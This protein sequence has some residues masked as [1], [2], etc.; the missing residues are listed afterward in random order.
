MCNLD[1]VYYGIVTQSTTMRLLIN[2]TPFHPAKRDM[3]QRRPCRYSCIRSVLQDVARINY[4]LKWQAA[5]VE[6]Q[7]QLASSTRNTKTQEAISKRKP[8]SP[9]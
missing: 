2:V 4:H 3:D 7:L 1:T 9:P 6:I 8:S 5:L